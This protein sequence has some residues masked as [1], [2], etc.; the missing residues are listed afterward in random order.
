MKQPPDL[1]RKKPVE[2]LGVG[3]RGIRERVRQLGG[4]LELLSNSDGTLI[5]AKLPYKSPPS[6]G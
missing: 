4:I 3:I 6:V 2:M 1:A 5:R